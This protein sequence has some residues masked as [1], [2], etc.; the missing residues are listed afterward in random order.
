MQGC[1]AFGSDLFQSV[2][3]ELLRKPRI[4]RGIVEVDGVLQNGV[5]GGDLAGE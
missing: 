2:G 5:M 1:V 4:D 3:C